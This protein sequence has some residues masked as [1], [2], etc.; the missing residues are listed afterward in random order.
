MVLPLGTKICFTIMISFLVVIGGLFQSI[1]GIQI[2]P[3]LTSGTFTL[4]FFNK[5]YQPHKWFPTQTNMHF[6]MIIPFF[7]FLATVGAATD[8][9]LQET[10]QQYKKTLAPATPIISPL[11]SN[12]LGQPKVIIQFEFGGLMGSGIISFTGTVKP[13]MITGFSV[14]GPLS[15]V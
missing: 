15:L 3:K 12:S 5:A 14:N 8:S 6:F 10:V 11:K 9:L 1:I 4:V 13:K 7:I 2:V